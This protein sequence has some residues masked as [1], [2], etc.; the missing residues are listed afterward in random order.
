MMSSS[1]VSS[2]SLPTAMEIDK[3]IK[4]I[5]KLRE[6]GNEQFKKQKWQQAISAYSKAISTYCTVFKRTVDSRTRKEVI[7][8]GIQIITTGINSLF[9]TVTSAFQQEQPVV[10]DK[11][12]YTENM[13]FLEQLTLLQPHV[14]YSNRS[15]AYSKVKLYD[16]ALLDGLECVSMNPS[17]PK[18][19][20]RVAEA[21]FLLRRFDE[22]L[23]SYYRSLTKVRYLLLN[24]VDNSDSI[25]KVM[26]L[27]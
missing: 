25:Q 16:E 22:A 23:V 19:H 13:S 6:E 11:F 3:Q 12:T 24:S 8:N 15:C 27:N 17:W 2:S 4:S 7:Q 9:S 5:I 10:E 20:F 26:G 18:S 1:S 21:L 14:L